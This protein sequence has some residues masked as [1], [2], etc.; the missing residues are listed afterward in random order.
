MKV[1]PGH[2]KTVTFQHSTHAETKPRFTSEFS[3]QTWGFIL[4]DNGPTHVDSFSYL[5]PTR[6]APT[7]DQ[8]PLEL[9]YGP[10]VCLDVAHVPP[11]T[12]IT[13][14]HCEDALAVAGLTIG[15]GDFCFFHTGCF[16]RSNGT[17]EYLRD[18]CGVGEEAAEWLAAHKVKA[19][20]IDAPTVD[21][22][23]STIYPAH[24]MSRR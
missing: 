17:D 12:D 10:G 6:G 24:L 21:N 5:D 13:A 4:N 9:F 18:F 8:M 3:F 16:E 2:L 14:Q 22:P 15:E 11:R 1:Y 19:Y 23:T 7:I 20:G